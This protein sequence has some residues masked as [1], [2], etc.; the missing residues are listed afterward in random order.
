MENGSALRRHVAWIGA[1]CVCA[2]AYAL[3][4]PR[5]AT[6][7]AEREA[8]AEGRAVI[9][10]WDR[11]SGHE[12][13]ARRELIDEFNRGQDEVL[14]RAL[15]IGYNSLMEKLLTSI[16]GG[17]PPDICALDGTIMAQLVA[18]GCFLPIE[19]FM[20]RSPYLDEEDFFPHMWESVAF[21]GHVWGVPT[22]TDT[23]C[24]L[25][26]KQAFRKAGLDPERPPQT[27]D[28]LAE[29]AERLTIRDETG[30]QQIGFLPWQPWDLT[31]MYGLLFGGTWYDE[32]TG[33]VVCAGDR[34]LL[35]MLE[36][37]RGFSLNPNSSDNAPY[38]LE[39]Q[40]IMSFQQGYGAYMSANNPFYSGKVAMITEG[41]WQST[42]IPKY[43]PELD[44][45]VAFIPTPEGAPQRAYSATCVADCIPAGC[46]HPEAAWAFLE[47]FNSPRADG[48]PSP[49]SD[50]NYAIHNIP[51][52]PVE[53]Q[54]D[55]FMQDPKF[56]LFVEVLLE[57]EVVSA[58]VSPA[59]QFM[60]D[61]IERQRE[62]IV[63]W[64]TTPEEAL[65]TIE[66]KVNAQ[67]RRV[68]DLIERT[69]S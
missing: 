18:Q 17:T 29:Y 44:W 20:A 26:N 24:L 27:F 62:R 14:V 35:R 6:T 25:W 3:I 51:V 68:R 54:Q 46:R 45:G 30:L 67:L 52:R 10:Y 34:N 49:A 39:P 12:H 31:H 22:T 47:W 65:E 60:M 19:A 69:A 1:V 38:A 66:T 2:L 53:A 16:A 50:Y 63:H 8:L 32:A 23:Y 48:R 64:K 59:T 40:K 9:V 57:R 4:W 58:P 15:P 37:Q 61:E 43:A 28:E 33:Q 36:W 11:H 5:E 21:D 41:E 42:F 56:K 7:E 55:R 13:E